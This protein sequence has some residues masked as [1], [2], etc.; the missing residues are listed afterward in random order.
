MTTMTFTATAPITAIP[1]I[2]LPFGFK[3]SDVLHPISLALMLI[4]LMT[5]LDLI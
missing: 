2:T 3:N 5:S 1:A 4:N